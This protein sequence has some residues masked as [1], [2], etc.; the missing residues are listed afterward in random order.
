MRISNSCFCVLLAAAVCLAGCGK[1]ERNEAVQLA[2][3]LT[4]TADLAISVATV[5]F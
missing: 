4:A 5:A 2:K 3:A 1:Q